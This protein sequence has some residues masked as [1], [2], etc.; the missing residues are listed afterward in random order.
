MFQYLPAL[1]PPAA[2]RHA[3][4]TDNMRISPNPTSGK[5]LISFDE[6]KEIEMIEIFDLTGRLVQ[7]IEGGKIDKA[8]KHIYVNGLPNGI[9]NVN[10][11][12]TSGMLYQTKLIIKLR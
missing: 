5:A 3:E 11:I 7:K 8:G 12:T 2:T 4:V 1:P 10:A 9:Y 6:A